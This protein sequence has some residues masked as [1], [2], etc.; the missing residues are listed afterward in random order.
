MA[1]KPREKILAAIVALLLAMA[2]GWQVI[3]FFSGPVAALR[4]QRS[5]LEQEVKDKQARIDRYKTAYHRQRREEMLKKL[6]SK[7]ARRVI[8]T[9]KEVSLGRMNSR[10]RRL[11]HLSLQGSNKVK[12]YSRGKGGKKELIVSP[13]R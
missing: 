13:K 8:A 10:D 5:Q 1:L 6:A 11:I 4:G 12:T 7:T 9:G 3:S 2:G